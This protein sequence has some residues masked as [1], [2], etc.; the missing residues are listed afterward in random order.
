[1]E[2]ELDNYHKESQVPAIASFYSCEIDSDIFW[3][4][5]ENCGVRKGM[6]LC[7]A[8]LFCLK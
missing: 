7:N 3:F 5:I 6:A 2:R 1:V 4:R 8:C